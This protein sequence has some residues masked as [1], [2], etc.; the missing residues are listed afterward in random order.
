MTLT[1]VIE[2]FLSGLLAVIAKFIIDFLNVKREEAKIKTD[3]ELARKYID[4][5]T[6]TVTNCVIATNQTYVDSLKNK[7]A[8][9][10]KAQEEAF[11][12]TLN[13]VSKIL[14]EEVISYLDEFTGDANKYI[15]TLIEAEVARKKSEKGS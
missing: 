6:K 15:I 9:D 7:N 8:F 13:A 12:M 11:N 5:V 1:S 14:S 4:M 2:V 3:S 10:K